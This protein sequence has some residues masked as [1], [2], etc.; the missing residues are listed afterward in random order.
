MLFEEDIPRNIQS[1]LNNY[2]MQNQTK[3]EQ[4]ERLRSEDTPHPRHP[5]ITHPRRPMITH[6]IESH[7][8]Q[9]Q[10]MTKS[11]LQ[12]K[13]ICQKLKFN[14]FELNFTRDTPSGAAW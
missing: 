14:N 7:W 8:I 11:K 2:N 1:A 9:S 3:L 10:N 12:I 5:M 13:R 6:T 4:L